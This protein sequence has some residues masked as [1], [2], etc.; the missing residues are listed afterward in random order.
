MPR[1]LGKFFAAIY[2]TNCCAECGFKHL[3]NYR[4]FSEKIVKKR[5]ECIPDMYFTLI[6]GLGKV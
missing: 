4:D 2:I 6:T 3:F 1:E 5:V